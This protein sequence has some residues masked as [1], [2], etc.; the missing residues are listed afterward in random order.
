MSSKL[1]TLIPSDS[2]SGNQIIGIKEC[3]ILSKILNRN[4]IIPPIRE[5]YLKSNTT[6]YDFDEIFNIEKLDNVI[7][8]N[9]KMTILNNIGIINKYV[10]HSN[11]L[12]KKLR[13]ELLFINDNCKG[14]EILLKN[15]IIKNYES[16]N[17]L[18]QIK[19]DLL[20]IKHLFN[21]VAINECCFNGCFRCKLNIQFEKIYEDICSKWDYSQYI[22]NIADEYI[23]NNFKSNEYI[24][25]HI[26]LPDI[27]K[28][29]NL[30][31]YDNLISNNKLLE[32]INNVKKENDKPIFI[33]SNNTKFLKK[34]GISFNFF[35]TENKHISFI[36][37]YICC[38]SVKFYYLNLCNFRFNQIHGRSTWTS[39][40]IDYR[41]YLN[42]KYNNINL[43]SD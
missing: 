11:Y 31:N 15:R 12:N 30:S 21:N 4:C 8:D 3:L 19:D 9:N 38:N 17:E 13:H 29:E 36:E 40:V 10:I 25:I 35:N 33:A 23:Y 2:G 34:I 27:I 16:I 6:F 24:S 26:R 18:K 41:N 42:K 1:I 32:I 5:H 7:I 20:I 28:G 37:Q 22:K 43:H 14:K 39:F